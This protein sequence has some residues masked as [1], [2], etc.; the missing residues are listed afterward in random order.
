[1]RGSE[2]G[3]FETRKKSNIHYLVRALCGGRAACIVGRL[4]RP[5]VLSVRE[6]GPWFT[7][8]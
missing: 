5:R 2:V 7:S 1:M 4:Q 8:T 6:F 3:C